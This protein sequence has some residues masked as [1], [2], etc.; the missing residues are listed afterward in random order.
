MARLP[1]GVCRFGRTVPSNRPSA[2]RRRREAF[3]T[4]VGGR[5]ASGPRAGPGGRRAPM[6]DTRHSSPECR[7]PSPG[8][9]ASRVTTI[10]VCATAH[11]TA[12][13]SQSGKCRDTSGL[14]RWHAIMPN[15]YCRARLTI[16]GRSKPYADRLIV[17]VARSAYLSTTTAQ[18]NPLLT[19]RGSRQRGTPVS[20]TTR[21]RAAHWR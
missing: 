7:V 12:P 2:R 4:R 14:P 1:L 5:R 6:Y 13:S 17:G 10:T 3:L 21:G 8:H 19:P 9:L 16:I 20:R 11:R 18:G 15:A